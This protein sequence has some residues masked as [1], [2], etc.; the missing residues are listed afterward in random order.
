M[1]SIAPGVPTKQHLR[2]V[3]AHVS[4]LLYGGLLRPRFDCG[5]L[6]MKGSQQC[7]APCGSPALVSSRRC[8]GKPH[9]GR[10]DEKNM[11]L[12]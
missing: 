6:S 3:P 11:L 4:R 12:M 9:Q 1:R 8:Q 10:C 5:A 2:C 7:L